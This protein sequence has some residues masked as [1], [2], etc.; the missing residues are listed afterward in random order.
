[1]Q[2][3][4]YPLSVDQN[5]NP[6]ISDLELHLASAKYNKS[7]SSAVG[8]TR[9]TESGNPWYDPT[10]GR[11]ANGPAGV[12]VRAGGAL[13]KNLLNNAKRYISSLASRTGADA[14]SARPGKNGL[15]IVS[16]YLDGQL[17]T[18]FS[19]PSAKS[20]PADDE[21]RNPGPIGQPTNKVGGR[22]VNVGKEEWAR[23]MDAVR[24]AAREFEPQEMEDIREWLQGKTNKELTEDE[25]K[26]FLADVREARV[27]DLVDI[28]DTSIRRREALRKRGRRQVKVVPPRGWV[29][30]TLANLEDNEIVE[31]HRRLGSRGFSEEELE[32][33]LINR[34]GEE[35]REKLFARVGKVNENK[36]QNRSS[37]DRQRRGAK[38]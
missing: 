4:W 31:L 16:L 26:Q 34:Y 25:I 12:S 38:R 22:P 28:L 7:S 2:H 37:N 11:F 15:V 6:V 13:L 9:N 23:R 30:R 8:A 36:T 33:H 27:D 20:N 32:K 29:R 14:I 5:G 21:A 1:M 10:T 17:I 24:S 19:V 3:R 35:R 18:E